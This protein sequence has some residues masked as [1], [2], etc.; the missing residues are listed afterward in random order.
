[1]KKQSND[2]LYIKLAKDNLIKN[3]QIYLP[4]VLMNIFL[5]AMFTIIR[6][7][8]LD[9]GIGRMSGGGTLKL[10]MSFGVGVLVV[11]S[12]VLVFYTNGFLMKRRKKEIGVYNILGFSKRHI[13]KMMSVETGMIATI[14]TALGILAGL[15]LMKLLYLL[16]L[17]L[18]GYPI[19]LR[20]PIS[21]Q[22]VGET[23]GLF[24]LF[25]TLVTLYNLT[26]I[27]LAKPIELIRGSQVG[28][29]EPKTRWILAVSGFIALAGA[30]YFA[31]T[32]V[33]PIQAISV[34][35]VAVVAVIYGT[36]A[37]FT[38]GSIVLLKLLRANKKIYYQIQNFSVIS[39]MLYRMKQHAAGLATLCILSTMVMISVSTTV[40]LYAGLEDSLAINYPREIAIIA[41]QAPVEVVDLLR[42]HTIEQAKQYGVALKRVNTSKTLFLMTKWDIANNRM[43][44]PE[45]FSMAEMLGVE[46]MDAETYRQ[47]H[48]TID[49]GDQPIL[50]VN[51]S[52]I[53]DGV[54]KKPQAP[55]LTI[56][57]TTLQVGRV[58][59]VPANFTSQLLAG[60]V[61][62][63]PDTE[64]MAMFYVQVT[65]EPFEGFFLR[66]MADIEG[67]QRERLGFAQHLKD[68][69]YTQ[70]DQF[71]SRVESRSIMRKEFTDFYG[72]MLFLGIFLGTLFLAATVIIMYYKQITEGYEDQSRYETM[73]K[74]GMHHQEIKKAINVQTII[75]F[76]LPL[77]VASL[78]ILFSFNIVRALLAI[79]NFTNVNLFIFC[80]AGTAVAFAFVYLF[81]YRFTAKTYFSIVK[82]GV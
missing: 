4:F 5:V 21:L 19:S 23:V 82:W 79:F 28:E 13:A 17:K 7:I 41:N 1:M 50:A 8:S 72:G 32:V 3:R 44:T 6:T 46:L 67:T 33:S 65:D 53:I 57:S 9:S 34:F 64:S 22:A 49:I 51:D 62:V 48:G 76:F 47:F 35:F 58:I 18:T 14:C 29:R 37:L 56:N 10:L 77:I 27:T 60:A 11:F 45:D 43:T 25:F 78:H 80:S 59:S 68:K 73:Q 30:Y 38:T 20:M 66:V 36:Y 69:P 61:L 40:S 42:E 26:H 31:I 39:G 15:I 70:Q 74:V 54:T 75:V 24:F 16:L 12:G 63:F 81:F 2:N 71:F 55:A 52:K